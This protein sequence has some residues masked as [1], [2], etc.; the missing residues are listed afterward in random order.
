LTVPTRVSCCVRACTWVAGPPAA[1]GLTE[2]DAT[3]GTNPATAAALAAAITTRSRERRRPPAHQSDLMLT[4]APL[5]SGPPCLWQRRL[6]ERES[7]DNRYTMDLISLLY[8]RSRALWPSNF[9]V[10]LLLP[11]R[12]PLAAPQRKR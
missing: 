2:A 7:R 12:P 6:A 11:V 1:R 4:I 5:T 9:P 8:S 3:A 10:R